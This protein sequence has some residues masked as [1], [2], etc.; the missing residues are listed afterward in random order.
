MDLV[1]VLNEVKSLVNA[2]A[3]LQKKAME[4]L[5]RTGAVPSETQEKIQKLAGECERL[6]NVYNDQKAES[7]KQKAE[8][9]KRD[10]TYTE[11]LTQLRAKLGDLEKFGNQKQAEES[12]SLGQVFVDSAE[13]KEAVAARTGI[14]RKVEVK[15]FWMKASGDMITSPHPSSI[16]STDL[17]TPQRIGGIQPLPNVPLTVRSLLPVGRTS[18]NMIEFVKENVFTNNAGPQWPSPP[19]QSPVSDGALKNKSNV[20]WTLVQRPVSTIAHYMKASRQ[21]LDDAPMLQ[22][23]INNRLLYG[24]AL[25]EE[26]QLL[27]GDGNSGNQLGLIPQA[28]VYNTA[29]NVAGDTKIDKLRHALLQVTLSKYLPTAIVLSPKDWHDIELTKEENGG[30]NKGGYVLSNPALQTNPQL[31]GYRVVPSLSMPAGTFLVGNFST[32]AQI[33]DRMNATVEIARQNED[34]F[35][36]NMVSILAEERLALAVYNGA[37]FVEGI[38]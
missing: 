17:T 20:T 4:E 28:A 13:Y 12:R 10:L 19:G 16:G 8:A 14:S 11:T 15:S 30:A 9:D 32:G 24:L 31:W 23:E 38:F 22:S 33:F 27:L 25:E 6:T 7:D 3:D 2:Q 18:N 29:L 35:V 36:R 26:E 5:K 34:D 1:D 37:C 21:I